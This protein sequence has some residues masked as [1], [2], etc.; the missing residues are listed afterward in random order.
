MLEMHEFADLYGRKQAGREEL[1]FL[2]KVPSSRVLLKAD[3]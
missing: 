1:V 2:H 3:L